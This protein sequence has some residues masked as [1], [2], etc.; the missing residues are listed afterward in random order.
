MHGPAAQHMTEFSTKR[1]LL[2]TTCDAESV[3]VSEPTVI[4]LVLYSMFGLLYVFCYGGSHGAS[5]DSIKV[6]PKEPSLMRGVESRFN[7]ADASEAKRKKMMEMKRLFFHNRRK[8][9][10]SDAAQGYETD[11]SSISFKEKIGTGT[12]G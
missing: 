12:Y 10:G 5:K 1:S 6:R 11:Y 4:F 7:L 8:S 2:P 9:D 3:G